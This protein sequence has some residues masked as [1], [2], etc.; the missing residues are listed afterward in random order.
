[1]PAVKMCM[2]V[3]CAVHC[4]LVV[5]SCRRVYVYTYVYVYVY[6]RSAHGKLRAKLDSGESLSKLSENNGEYPNSRVVCKYGKSPNSR[7]VQNLRMHPH[8]AH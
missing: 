1:M 7:V 4:A 5:S 6:F 3:S 2:G 8:N